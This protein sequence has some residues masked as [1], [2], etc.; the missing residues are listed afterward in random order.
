M[1]TNK[2]EIDNN[3]DDNSDN[4]IHSIHN[5]IQKTIHIITD[6][7]EQK[8]NKDLEILLKEEVKNLETNTNSCVVFDD[9]L[10]IRLSFPPTFSKTISIN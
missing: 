6:S 9:M 3:F 10:N 1:S 7:P 8:V 4:N 5:N 2:N